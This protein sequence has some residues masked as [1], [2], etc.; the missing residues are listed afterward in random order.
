[1]RSIPDIDHWTQAV[2]VIG[3]GAPAPPLPTS[4]LAELAND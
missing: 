4:L 2:K 3:T 1:M